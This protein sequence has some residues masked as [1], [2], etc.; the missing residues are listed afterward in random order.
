M[1]NFVK[2]TQS[3]AFSADRLKQS[4]WTN[5]ASHGEYQPG[6]KKKQTNL[7]GRR[8]DRGNLAAVT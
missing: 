1:I 7:K 6:E 8:R 4:L 2:V 3:C 5:W